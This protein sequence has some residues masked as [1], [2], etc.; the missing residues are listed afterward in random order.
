MLA[1]TPFVR[2]NVHVVTA[3]LL[4]IASACRSGNVVHTSAEAYDSSSVERFKTFTISA[5]EPAVGRVVV[6]ATND[7]DRVA[8]AKMDMDPML[9]T[10]LVG[11]AIRQDLADAFKKRGYQ[12]VDGPSDFYIAYY[13]GTGTVVDTRASE[14]KYHGN[15]EHV[16]TQTYEYP[17]GT[18]V[19]DVVDASTNALVWRGTG[20]S[21]IPNKP[22]DYAGAVHSTVDK[23]VSSFPKAH[24]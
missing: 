13:A 11:R 1:I 9:S 2:R 5:P 10:S 23:I 15:G 8:G 14:K 17:A 20:V 16:T 24:R 19:V 12:P 18:I 4:V 6:A 21:E 3:G 22:D 7:V